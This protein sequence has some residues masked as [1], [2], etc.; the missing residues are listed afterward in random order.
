[1]LKHGIINDGACEG[2]SR[3]EVSDSD[4]LTNLLKCDLNCGGAGVDQT[5]IEV[6]LKGKAYKLTTTWFK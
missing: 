1:M 4:K 2:Q 3:F 6:A 5:R